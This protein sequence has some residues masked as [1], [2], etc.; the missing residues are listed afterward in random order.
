LQDEFNRLFQ[1]QILYKI[2]NGEDE[3]G[4]QRVIENDFAAQLIT[5]FYLKEPHTAHQKTQIFTDNYIKIFNRHI[6]ASYIFLVAEMYRAID[7]NKDQIEDE[8]IRSYRLTRFFFVYVFRVIFES[9]EVGKE[10]I[11][12]PVA[13]LQKYNN[14]YFKAF[15]KLFRLLALDF[16]YYVNNEKEKGQGYFDHKNSLRNAAKVKEMADEIVKSYKRQL[17]RHPEDAFSHLITE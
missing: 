12:D 16:N 3:K 6:N 8:G 4:Y 2:K 7:G 17:I 9:D 13:F 11:A 15:E 1:K 14:K 10:L 5:A